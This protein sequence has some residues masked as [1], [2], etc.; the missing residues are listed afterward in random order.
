MDENSSAVERSVKNNLIT[1]FEVT[2]GQFETIRR[3]QFTFLLLALFILAPTQGA[4][5]QTAPTA[6]S[7]TCSTNWH[8]GVRDH[9]ASPA[10]GHRTP[11]SAG[12]I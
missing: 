7:R 3:F 9:Y 8:S 11:T 2:M 4:L 5:A 10:F 6:T 1:R 12:A